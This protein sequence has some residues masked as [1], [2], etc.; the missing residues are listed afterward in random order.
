MEIRDI[1]LAGVPL[2]AM[3]VLPRIFRAGVTVGPLLVSKYRGDSVSISV[4]I[5]NTGDVDW[6]F[7]I[8]CSIKDAAGQVWDIWNG[9]IAKTPGAGIDSRTIARGQTVTQSWVVTIPSDMALGDAQIRVSVWQESR[10]PVSNRLADTGWVSGLLKIAGVVAA[11]I[12][13][14]S[15]S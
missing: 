3:F 15:V 7:G 8:G 4:P 9:N 12:G 5:T 13:S 1:A 6:T 11:S 10:L 2:A 14:I